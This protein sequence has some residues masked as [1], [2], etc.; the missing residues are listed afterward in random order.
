MFT[1]QR[2]KERQEVMITLTCSRAEC[3]QLLNQNKTC[4]YVQHVQRDPVT[5]KETKFAR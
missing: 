4:R 5:N 3:A 2:V 1:K